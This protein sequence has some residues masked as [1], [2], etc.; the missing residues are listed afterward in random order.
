MKKPLS[1]SSLISTLARNTDLSPKDIARVL[2]ELAELAYREIPN[3]FTLP[4]LCKF[5]LVYR[6]ETR[7]YNP[8][9]RA[10]L[11]IAGYNVLKIVPLKKARDRMAPKPADLIKNVEP[12]DEVQDAPSDAVASPPPAPAMTAPDPAGAITFVCPHC[13]DT[14]MAQFK[15]RGLK[16]ECPVCNGHVLVPDD[17]VP[18]P[19]KTSVPDSAAFSAVSD[20]VTFVCEACEQEIEAP[21][22]MIGMDAACPACGSSLQVPTYDAVAKAANAESIQPIQSDVDHKSMTIR[23]DL[24]D[25]VG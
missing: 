21:L 9:M 1:K 3:D 17:S 22:E 2:D 12:A 5:K 11:Q 8:A 23:M 16:A 25:L 18:A 7:R 13:G 15:H 20:F 10:Y 24:S 14:I 4:G 19:T 6:K